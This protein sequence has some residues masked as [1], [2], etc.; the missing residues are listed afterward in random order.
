MATD[1]AGMLHGVIVRSDRPSARIRGI[2]T[3]AAESLPGVEV[4]VTAADAPGKFG[5]VIKDQ[6][7]FAHDQV[8]DYGAV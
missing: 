6:P 7:V 3:R 2:D 1:S 8:R 5:E 4:V